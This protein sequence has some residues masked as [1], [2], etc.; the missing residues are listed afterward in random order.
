MYAAFAATKSRLSKMVTARWYAAVRIWKLLNQSLIQL[1][2]PLLR[3]AFFILLLG[4]KIHI[5]WME[6]HY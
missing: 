1:T 2:S 3:W 5:F 4:E 6:G